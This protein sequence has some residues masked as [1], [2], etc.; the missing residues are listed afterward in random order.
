MVSSSCILVFAVFSWIVL[1]SNSK[2]TLSVAGRGGLFFFLLFEGVVVV[3]LG[4]QGRM[5][6]TEMIL[7]S[8]DNN[9]T[10]PVLAAGINDGALGSRIAGVLGNDLS[11]TLQD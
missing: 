7:E 5:L 8:S 6:E 9:C 3:V 1:H 11:V 10:A 4:L 2:H